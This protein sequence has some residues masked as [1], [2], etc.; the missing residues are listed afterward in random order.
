MNMTIS[1]LVC[2]CRE[3]IILIRDQR[4]LVPRSANILFWFKNGDRCAPEH[5]IRLFI[6]C[7]NDNSWTLFNT[8][9]YGHRLPVTS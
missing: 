3:D 2:V 5:H 4:S 6:V 7:A 1:E 8:H 9:P